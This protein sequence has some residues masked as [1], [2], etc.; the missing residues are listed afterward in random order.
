MTQMR[1]SF[2]SQRRGDL[3]EVVAEALWLREKSGLKDPSLGVDSAAEVW[4][5]KGTEKGMSRT[6]KTRQGL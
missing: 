2:L 1:W 5:R 3:G 6:K 4:H